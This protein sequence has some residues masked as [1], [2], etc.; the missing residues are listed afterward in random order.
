MARHKKQHYVPASYLKAWCDPNVARTRTPYVWIFDKEGSTSHHSAPGKI[1]RESDIYTIHLPDGERI[2]TIEEGLSQLEDRFTRIRNMKLN[3]SRPFDEAEHI[4][5][6]AF[7]AA[8][9]VRTPVMRDHHR[10]QWER[11]LKMME[12]MMEWFARAI[13]EEVER[14][15]LPTTLSSSDRSL[16]YEDIKAIHS[17]PMQKLLAPMIPHLTSR[18]CHLNFAILETDDEIGFITSDNPCVWFDPDGCRRPPMYRNPALMYETIEITLPVSPRQCIFLNRLGRA[19]YIQVNN[20]VLD[21]INRRTRFEADK[22]FIVRKN[23]TRAQWFD[24]GI[25]PED[26]W[27]RLH[28]ASAETDGF[29]RR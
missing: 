29:E 23:E 18:L 12:R 22:S 14:A 10:A 8:A 7:V 24:P 6:C 4:V 26:S 25:E 1:F 5:L 20:N 16:D 21:E 15:V 11:P 3:T 17:N 19:G 27:D 13:P 2:L 9:Q 28:K